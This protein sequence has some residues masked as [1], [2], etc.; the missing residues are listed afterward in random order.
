MK[1]G[2][3][4]ISRPL[5][6]VLSRALVASGVAAVWYHA[7]TVRRPQFRVLGYHSVTAEPAPSGTI[8]R[9]LGV[10]VEQ[11]ARQMAF[12]RARFTP[13]HLEEFA[14]YAR[15]PRRY[16]RPPIAVTFDDGYRD[17]VKTALPILEKFGI[18][19]TIFVTTGHVGKKAPFWWN[20]LSA[21]VWNAPPGRYRFSL[22]GEE[23]LFACASRKQRRQTFW[24]L[25]ADLCAMEE[26]ERPLVL[27]HIGTVLGA[28]CQRSDWG[29][30]MLSA[31]EIVGTKSPLLRFGA[32]TVHHVVL[33]K[34][35]PD[36]RRWEV[37][38]S[39]AHLQRWT[40]REVSSFAYP[41]G[42]AAS[43][44]ESVQKVVAEAGIGCAVTTLK[45]ANSPTENPLALRRT[46]IDGGD[47]FFVFV[48]KA[49]GLFDPSIR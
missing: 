41:L 35:P 33:T 13:V 7:V 47:D 6:H 36:R 23:H 4:W 32:H 30:E 19:A 10:P 11:F 29:P 28:G 3:A 21:W 25:F 12:L 34:V 22:H 17:N 39:V 37:E 31:E 27:S 18:P 44:D 15:D 8:E 14:D 9:S 1:S 2:N 16:V 45:G 49:L 40:R 38:E 43:V 5:K 26:S 20:A 24:H 42:D 46:L 48:C